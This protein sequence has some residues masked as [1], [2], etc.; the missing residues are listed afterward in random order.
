[1]GCQKA[2]GG[3]EDAATASGGDVQLGQEAGDVAERGGASAG[4]ESGGAEVRA[5]HARAQRAAGAAEA[6]HMS[7][8][9]WRR[10]AE[11]KQR[12]ERER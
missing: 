3:A 8:Q 11:E 7:E 5:T 2:G 6:A 9:W 10:V 1:V 12:R 4:A